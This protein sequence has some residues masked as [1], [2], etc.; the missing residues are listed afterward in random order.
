MLKLGQLKRLVQHL[1]RSDIHSLSFTEPGFSL[2]V[3]TAGRP[4]A[5]PAPTLQAP[6]APPRNAAPDAHDM[7]LKSPMIGVFMASH[8]SRPTQ[9][10]E[11]GR[12]VAAD[13]LLGLISVAG[14][15]YRAVRA[16]CAGTIVERVVGDGERLQFGSLLFRLRPARKEP[17]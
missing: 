6:A 4:P 7:A 3:V 2:R 5:R 17:A 10:T 12:Q 14:G 15:L 16:P 1:E 11:A 8:P 9:R 13:E